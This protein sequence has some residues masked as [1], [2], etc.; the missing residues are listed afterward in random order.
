MNLVSEL[1][2]CLPKCCECGGLATRGYDRCGVPCSHCKADHFQ[3]L[4]CDDCHSGSYY[5]ED[6]SYAEVVRKII[7]ST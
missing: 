5:A 4:I 7:S 6:L 1:I 2:N 3:K